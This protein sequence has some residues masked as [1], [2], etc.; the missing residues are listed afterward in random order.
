M[1]TSGP[2]PGLGLAVLRVV[3]GVVF[4]THGSPKLFQGG[5]GQTAGFFAQ[6]GIPLPEIAAW[7]VTLLEFFGGIALIVGLLVTPIALL[8]CFH[9]LMGIILVH[10][11]NGWFVIGPGQGGVEFN[12]TLIAGLLT[13]VLAGPGVAALDTRRAGEDVSEMGPVD[14]GTR[15]PVGGGTPG[16]GAR[17]PDR[18]DAVDGSA[19]MDSDVPER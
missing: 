12:V 6:L 18:S 9:M 8:F 14:T 5:V 10:A 13:L 15:G 16:S 2:N 1:R 4:V 19:P 3:L 17:A 7:V 11:P